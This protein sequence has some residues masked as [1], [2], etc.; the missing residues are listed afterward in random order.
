M[1]EVKREINPEFINA[2]V[3]QTT[4]CFNQYL[5]FEVYETI[6]SKEDKIYYA[7]TFFI[8]NKRK[9]GFQQLRSTGKDGIKSLLWA[10]RC[11]IDFM[12][13]IKTKDY[14]QSYITISWED[15]HRKRVYYWGLKELG[16]YLT[17]VFGKE[18]LLYKINVLQHIDN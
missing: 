15:S 5:K 8:S 7:V 6:D 10:K 11:L 16:F 9:Q 1:Y 14:P 12:E 13:Y 3:Y 18:V 4:N 17:R 2:Y